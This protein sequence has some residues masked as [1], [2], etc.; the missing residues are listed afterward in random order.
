MV[1]CMDALIVYSQLLIFNTITYAKENIG[2]QFNCDL[3]LFSYVAEVWNTEYQK[4]VCDSIR[5][6]LKSSAVVNVLITISG[7]TLSW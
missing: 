3:S 6:Q 5:I 4:L 7:K 1:G 2:N